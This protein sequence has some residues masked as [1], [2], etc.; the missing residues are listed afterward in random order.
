MDTI[1]IPNRSGG[2]NK[3][4]CVRF[5][6]LDRLTLIK[7]LRHYGYSPNPT[8]G[9]ETLAA[10]VTNCFEGKKMQQD[11]LNEKEMVTTI[12]SSFVDKCARNPYPPEANPQMKKG[13]IGGIGSGGGGGGGGV[14]GG[15]QARSK[16]I[17][18]GSGANIQREVAK[19]GEQVA[20]RDPSKTDNDD[21]CWILASIIEVS[22][23][24]GVYLVQDED[25]S[26]RQGL[27]L[28][29]RDVRKLE[30]SGAYLRKGD[31]ILA[32]FP[33]T[34][35]FYRA[36]VAKTPKS[37][38]GNASDVVVRFDDDD[39]DSGRSPLR[40]VPARFVIKRSDVE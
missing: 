12:I 34:T 6:K 31:S 38:N 7:I 27:K 26:V 22:T 39:D 30:D 13:G 21:G 10:S 29:F 28:S 18:G 14:G 9:I 37:V 3:R 35:S 33:E 5:D 16:L 15:G 20:A 11:T 19:V 32:V 40:K 24:L 1:G 23:Q 4:Q 17:G 2:G 25:D 36:I 8:V